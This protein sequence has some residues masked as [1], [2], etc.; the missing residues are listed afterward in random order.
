MRK[1]Y[2]QDGKIV[3]NKYAVRYERIINNVKAET[4]SE[5]LQY[6]AD[7]IELS[8]LLGELERNEI[9][10]TVINLD[11]EDILKYDGIRVVSEEEAR[12]LIEPAL[13]EVKGDKIKE[14]SDTCKETIFKGINVTLSDGSVRHFSLKTED[15]INLNGLLGQINLGNIKPENGVPYHAD[16]EMCTLFSVVDFTL[17]ANTAMSFILRQTTYCNHL[18]SYVKSLDN[19]SDVRTVVY[20]RELTGEFLE[21][22][23]NIIGLDSIK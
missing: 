16:G 15:Q 20:G 8:G 19:V 6:A 7:D 21:S 10:Y 2:V 4:K 18:M 13:E 3:I 14:I 22:Y 5:V 9:A 12:R 17:I 23:N 11:T 1:Y